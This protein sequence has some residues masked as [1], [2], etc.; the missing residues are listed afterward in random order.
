MQCRHAVSDQLVSFTLMRSSTSS[1]VL[2]SGHA[3]TT[4]KQVEDTFKDFTQRDNIAI[5]L[6]NQSVSMLLFVHDLA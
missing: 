1:Q 3:E 4:V 5:V 6:I 2:I